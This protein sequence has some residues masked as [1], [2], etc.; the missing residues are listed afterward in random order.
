MS[1]MGSEFLES[2]HLLY[3]PS[4]LFGLPPSEC[5][6]PVWVFHLRE[7]LTLLA[8][9]DTSFRFMQLCD[10]VGLRPTVQ[11]PLIKSP[12]LVFDPNHAPTPMKCDVPKH[13][14]CKLMPCPTCN[15]CHMD[16]INHK[17][18]LVS[19]TIIS[20][21]Y[22]FQNKHSFNVNTFGHTY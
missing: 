19:W 2:H 20:H 9:P 21:A 8:M 18:Y 15:E 13:M 1:F 16:N 22:N 10:S 11:S 4:I 7:C 14:R 17:I 5:S 6:K 12:I 3:T